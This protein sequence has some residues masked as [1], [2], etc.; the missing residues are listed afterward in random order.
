M[1]QVVSADFV[2]INPYSTKSI[3]VNIGQRYNVIVE[4]T[5]TSTTAD[6]NPIPSNNRFWIRTGVSQCGGIDNLSVN[7]PL[8]GVISY[9]NSTSPDPT[10]LPWLNATFPDCADE[11]LASIQPVVPWDVLPANNTDSAL[12]VMSGSNNTSPS[13]FYAIEPITSQPA[14][15]PLQIDWANVTFLNLG[16]AGSWPDLWAVVPEEFSSGFDNHTPAWASLSILCS[17]WR[18]N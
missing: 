10:S 8:T 16:N 9:D 1:L 2:P 13:A 14:F 3:R 7:A 17:Y 4:A 12:V 6:N 11:P 18:L 5:P 15:L